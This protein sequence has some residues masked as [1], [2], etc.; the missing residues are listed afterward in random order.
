MRLTAMART[1]YAGIFITVLS[2]HNMTWAQTLPRQIEVKAR[3]YTFEPGEITLRKGEPVLIVIKSMD[4]AHG[5]R[6]REFNAEVNVRAGGSAQ[7][8][9]TPDRTGDFVGHCSVFC[10]SG[11]G[12]MILKLHVVN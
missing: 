12:S 8:Q 11:H 1:L 9:F 6:F 2:A 5:L 10:G 7:M 3:R 4:V